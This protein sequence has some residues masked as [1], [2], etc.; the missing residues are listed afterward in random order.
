MSDWIVNIY[1]KEGTETQVL[2]VWRTMSFVLEG[3]T[4]K[5]REENGRVPS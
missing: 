1:T 4:R 5:G 2:R 3:E